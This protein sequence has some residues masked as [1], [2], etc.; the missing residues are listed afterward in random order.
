MLGQEAGE[1]ANSMA[2]RVTVPG[3]GRAEDEYVPG[4]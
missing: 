1:M 2:A 4:W 3:S